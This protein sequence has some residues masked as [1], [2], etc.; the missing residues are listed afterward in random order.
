EI[1]D[2]VFGCDVCQEVCPWNAPL[3]PAA[4]PAPPS[5]REWL[6]LGPGAWRRTFGATALNRAGRRGMQRNAA[7]SLGS[8]GDSSARPALER[9]AVSSERGLRD[10]AIWALA[11][12]EE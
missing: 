1:G 8:S 4:E 5:R 3:L 6:D 12:I 7:V 9:A 2:H 10:A 11:R